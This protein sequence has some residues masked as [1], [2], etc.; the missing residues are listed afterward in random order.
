MKPKEASAIKYIL[1]MVALSAGCFF[2]F[3]GNIYYEGTL[4]SSTHADAAI[5]LGAAVWEDQPSPVFRERIN[6]AVQLYKEE[7]VSSIIFTGGV[8]S[9]K[10]YS[11]SE[12]A[13]IYAVQHGIPD[14]HIFVETV[15][16]TTF[17]N[18]YY[19]KRIG[20]ANHFSRFLIVSDPLHMKRARMMADDLS[21]DAQTSPTSTSLYKG[22]N[23][24][25]NFAF[26]EA[27]LIIRHILWRY[28]FN[29]AQ[30]PQYF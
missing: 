3:I 26:Q 4:T 22:V 6:H 10:K 21:L 15:S 13:K 5:V 17:Q 23:T 20:D 16:K 25:L 14:K 18:L 2:A 28:M 11:E 19:A 7:K 24:Q 1:L 8:G 29:P 12:I 27:R 30:N 9:G